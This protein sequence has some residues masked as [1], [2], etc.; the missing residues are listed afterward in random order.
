MHPSNIFLPG[1]SDYV[2]PSAV[3]GDPYFSSVVLLA[4]FSGADN[5]TSFTEYKNNLLTT[6]GT[7]KISTA[8]SKFGSGSL[9]VGNS[10]VVVSGSA[11]NAEFAFAGAFTWELFAYFTSFTTA[12]TLLSKSDTSQLSVTREFALTVNNSTTL[13]LYYGVR[14]SNQTVYNAT[15]PAMP[16]N[17]WNHIA[18]TRDSS[19]L[20]KFFVN[21]VVSAN[22]YTDSVPLS[23]TTNTLKIGSFTETTNLITGRLEQVRLTNGVARNIVVPTAP[24]PTS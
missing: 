22:T 20:I 21:G 11:N 14:G 24:Y 12:Q 6:T 13:S 16:L 15:V 1:F 17:A 23:N 10:P 2:A 4:P 5:S 19:N 8:V 9:L 7:T 3:E 18:M